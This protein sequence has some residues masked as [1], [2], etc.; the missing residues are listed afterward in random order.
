MICCFVT[1]SVRDAVG[2]KVKIEFMRTVQVE[3]R[4]DRYESRIL[5]CLRYLIFYLQQIALTVCYF[6]YFIK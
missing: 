5:V 3:V 1:V 4:S 2:S 6:F